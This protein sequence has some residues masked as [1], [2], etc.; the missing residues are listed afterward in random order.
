MSEQDNINRRNSERLNQKGYIKVSIVS[1]NM[2]LNRKQFWC[3][4]RDL[5]GGGL[6]MVMHSN[7]PIGTMM[8]VKVVFID[9]AATF[10][11]MASVA[12]V[13]EN[14]D[15]VIKVYDVGIRF[16]STLGK[17][18]HEWEDMLGST[19]LGSAEPE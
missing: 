18:N 2:F 12:W 6:K 7:I 3:T 8:R 14:N 15:E 19:M 13:K 5:S 11:H 17:G 10:E 16:S 9:P 1:R 4:T